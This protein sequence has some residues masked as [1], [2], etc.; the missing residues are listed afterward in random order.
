MRTK[1]EIAA[2]IKDHEG[3]MFNFEVDVLLPYLDYEVAKPYLNPTVNALEWEEARIKEPSDEMI[4]VHARKY[5]EFAIGKAEDHRGL[6]AMRSVQKLAAWAWLLNRQDVLDQLEVTPYAPY[7]G[8]QLAVFCEAFNYH[9]PI[10]DRA[11]R[12]MD[13]HPCSPECTECGS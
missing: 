2:R 4:L 10:S 13:G 7:G 3:R 1:E 12:M 8:P 11:Q 5:L 6:S 9:L